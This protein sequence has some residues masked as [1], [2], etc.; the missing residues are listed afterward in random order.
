MHPP[1]HPLRPS[2]C[3]TTPHPSCLLQPLPPLYYHPLDPSS[4]FVRHCFTFFN[5]LLLLILFPFLQPLPPL[6]LSYF[7]FFVFPPF[8][9]YFLL[10]PSFD[11]VHPLVLTLSSS[12]S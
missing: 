7:L 1:P 5:F 9:P 8:P 12:S 3:L 4:S 10:L 6:Q 11:L 2:Y